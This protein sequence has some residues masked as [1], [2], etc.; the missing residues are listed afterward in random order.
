M[1]EK[2]GDWQWVGDA[3]SVGDSGGG[4]SS[5]WPPAASA[6]APPPPPWP[7][8]GHM[9][10]TEAYGKG[11]SKGWNEGHS[12]GHSAGFAAGFQSAVNHGWGGKGK[13]SGGWQEEEA[14]AAAGGKKKQKTAGWKE[15]NDLY[16]PFD[17]D[18][19]C[20]TYFYTRISSKKLEYYP[21]EI[22]HKLLEAS[23]ASETGNASKDI[24]YDMTNGWVFNLRIFGGSEQEDWE[25]KLSEIR[26]GDGKPD[27]TLV[28]AQW[29]MKEAMAEPPTV[30]EKGVKFRPIFYSGD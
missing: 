9:Y 20:I 24:E 30:F 13:G 14:Q 25:E 22:Q 8:P 21:Q 1:A 2:R 7:P 12:A 5:G 6:I 18:T 17:P 29:R 11:L 4:W 3:S 19:Q 16:T 15:W 10:L 23:E 26:A 27:G 28:G